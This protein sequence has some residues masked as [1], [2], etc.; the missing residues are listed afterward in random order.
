MSRH[1]PGCQ[2]L[3]GYLAVHERLKRV[4]IRCRP[5][6]DVIQQ[7]DSESTLFYLD[8]PYLQTTR[9]EGHTYAHEMTVDD[10]RELLR[11]LSGIRG[12][13]ILSGYPVTCTRRQD[14][15]ITG[16]AGSFT[17]SIMRQARPSKT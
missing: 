12:K 2:P 14:C 16:T 13:F 6:A 7:E 17:L 8:P 5:A 9:S 4:V 3:R 1:P 11:L 10:H 15:R